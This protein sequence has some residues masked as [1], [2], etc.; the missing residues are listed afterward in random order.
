MHLSK[1][2]K[3]ALMMYGFL[4]VVGNILISLSLFSIETKCTNTNLF[5]YQS[6]SFDC[7]NE[8]CYE[9]NRTYISYII[10]WNECSKKNETY[11]KTS[12][13]KDLINE[14]Q[15]TNDT[16]CYYKMLI[17]CEHIDYSKSIGPPIIIVVV[18]NIGIIVIVCYIIRSEWQYNKKKT[19]EIE[20]SIRN[21]EVELKE[22]RI[23]TEKK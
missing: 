16:Y 20:E 1:C 12:E 5:T 4:F 18:Y 14:I 13:A 21:N 2:S 8:V 19:E 17:S 15:K 11:I 22:L 3:I 9:Y 7:S 23:K 6:A 10:R